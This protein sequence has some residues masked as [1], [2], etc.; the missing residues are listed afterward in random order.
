M[1]IFLF[2]INVLATLCFAR[3]SLELSDQGRALVNRLDASATNV[4]SSVS[5]RSIRD[6]LGGLTFFVGVIALES[7]I[8]LVID[9]YVPT[10]SDAWRNYWRTLFI[11]SSLTGIAITWIT[12]P[13]LF[14]QPLLGFS[15]WFPMMMFL[16][17]LMDVLTGTSE[18][19]RALGP[20]ADVYRPLG[21][22]LPAN[23]WAYAAAAA[24]PLM[25]LY[26]AVWLSMTA[27]AWAI[28]TPVAAIA[29]G[30][31]KLASWSNRWFPSNGLTPL[32]FLVMVASAAYSWSW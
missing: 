29:L 30:T 18:A 31:I 7:L 24:L 9:L 13:T 21:I 12:R 25:A 17:P 27:M 23:A 14:N 2:L 28:I 10:G 8:C 15:I 4:I 5:K 11:C 22:A 6:V 3:N 16:L 20:I 26:L 1:S 32:C 19:L